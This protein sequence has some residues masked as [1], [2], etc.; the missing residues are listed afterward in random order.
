MTVLHDVW[1]VGREIGASR[2]VSWKQRG[3]AVL[4][5]ADVSNVQFG[6]RHTKLKTKW[7]GDGHKYVGWGYAAISIFPR[8]LEE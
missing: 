7:G 4:A 2:A 3:G 1:H 8:A 6:R 5:I